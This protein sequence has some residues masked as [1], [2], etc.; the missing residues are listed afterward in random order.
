MPLMMTLVKLVATLFAFA[1]LTTSSAAAPKVSYGGSSKLG[2]VA[3]G[4]TPPLSESQTRLRAGQ[5]VIIQRIIRGGAELRHANVEVANVGSVSAKGV[6]VYLQQSSNVAY[7]LRGPR[8]LSPHERG[9]YI[10]N[11]RVLSGTG[12]WSVVVRCSTCRR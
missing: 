7:A 8:E 3:A 5:P 11:S 4:A 6:Q 10:L 9:T 12:S 2:R 1:G